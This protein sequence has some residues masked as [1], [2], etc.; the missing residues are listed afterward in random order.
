MSNGFL[1]AAAADLSGLHEI[2]SGF[3]LD[4]VSPQ[5]FGTDAAAANAMQSAA[6]VGIVL[7]DAATRDAS[8]IALLQV[9]AR[10][11]RTAQLILS[12]PDLRAA[13]GFLPDAWP[14][15][16]LTDA[17]ARATDLLRRRAETENGETTP[18]A[19][20]LPPVDEPAPPPPQPELDATPEQVPEE[21]REPALEAQPEPEAEIDDG[22]GGA[23]PSDDDLKPAP[24]G[25]D[26]N[27]L[28]DAGAVVA[29]DDDSPLIDSFDTGGGS[30]APTQDEA[31]PPRGRTRTTAAARAH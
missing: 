2:A 15:M 16:A 6:N 23:A 18:H 26:E 20:P 29:P 24:G 7:T 5:T 17:Q 14:V 31:P 4:A 10:T 25:V 19:H 9:L 30:G 13:F 21:P 28:S 12:E 3:G 27:A 11:L 22:V 1:L 8:Y